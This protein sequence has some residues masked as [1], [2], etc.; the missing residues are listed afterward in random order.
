MNK[1]GKNLSSATQKSNHQ[2]AKLGMIESL[3]LEPIKFKLISEH[4]W[5]LA[6]CDLVEK[7]YKGFL[8]LVLIQ[9]DTNFVP[10]L[11][12]DE[13]WHTHILDTRKYV[14]DCH[15]IF[16]EYIHHYPYLGMKDEADAAAA[17]EQFAHT[18][19]EHV[20]LFGFDVFADTAA[21][22]GGC[23]SCGGDGDGGTGDDS[24]HTPAPQPGSCSSSP[25]E[26]EK[27]KPK[28]KPFNYSRNLGMSPE[29]SAW[30]KSLTPT[31]LSRRYRPT[32]AEVEAAAR[33]KTLH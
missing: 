18:R 7:H 21:D 23:S 26:K 13:M 2:T 8:K 11:D 20:R 28:P 9:P 22:C 15:R 19:A 32:R 1:D 5:T 12:V 4:N 14:A 33:Q 30:E 17:R 27:D 29:Q 25:T 24:D 6:R 3:D 10:T 31:D 16:G